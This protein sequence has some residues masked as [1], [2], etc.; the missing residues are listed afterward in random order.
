MKLK[1]ALPII[2]TGVSIVGAIGSVLFAINETPKAIEVLDNHRL[3]VDPTGET[4]L[5][6]MEKAVDYAK[7]YWKTEICLG[8]TIVADILAC[9]TAQRQIKGLLVTAAGMSAVATK[10]KEEIKST[11]GS[12]KAKEIESKIKKEIKEAK[13]IESSEDL[14]SKK[15]FYEPMS[16]TCF[17]MTLTEFYQAKE[18]LNKYLNIAGVVEL[19]DVFYPLRKL[20]P[21]ACKSAWFYDDVVENGGYSWVEVGVD[22]INQPGSENGLIHWDVNDGRETY[23]IRY[24]IYPLPPNI[25]KDYQWIGSDGSEKRI[26]YVSSSDYGE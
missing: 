6:P 23:Y 17:Q 13:K 12:E 19:G 10:Y 14:T 25:A 26:Q 4:D 22:V 20:A 1:G 21:K 15:W 7:S 8:V 5:A 3:E 16:D 2:F 24:D 9:V 11:L 18:D